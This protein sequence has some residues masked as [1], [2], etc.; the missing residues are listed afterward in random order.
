MNLSRYGLLMVLVGS[1]V[2][3]SALDRVGISAPPVAEAKAT[4]PAPPPLPPRPTPPRPSDPPM[5]TVEPK[6]QVDVWRIGRIVATTTGKQ[7]QVLNLHRAVDLFREYDPDPAKFVFRFQVAA[8][9]VYPIG[10]YTAAGDIPSPPAICTITAGEPGPAPPGPTPPGPVPPGPVPP[11]PTPGPAPIPIAGL[12]V[13]IVEES[14]DRAK[15]TLG[16]HATLFGRETRDYL[17][18]KCATDPHV[19]A[20][21]AYRIWDK[22]TVLAE[23]GK[24]WADAMARPRTS[25]PWLIVSD[26]K[27]GYEGPL[28]NTVAE[29]MTILKKFAGE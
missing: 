5:V 22:N 18:L 6:L 17:D 29:T 28:P 11:G 24:T 10:F 20:W 21:K 14:A 13:L 8:P 16:Q 9:G 2:G 4:P 3:V 7:I 15:L 19:A 1:L 12:S 26:G 23:A 25:T 27:G